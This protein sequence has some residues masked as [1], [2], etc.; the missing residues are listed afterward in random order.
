MQSK[1]RS[2][3]KKVGSLYGKMMQKWLKRVTAAFF[4]FPSFPPLPLKNTTTF[5]EKMKKYFYYKNGKYLQI[6]KVYE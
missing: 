4:F 2:E 5:K 6:S 3:S 1:L